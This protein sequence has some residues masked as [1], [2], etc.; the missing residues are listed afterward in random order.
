MPFPFAFAWLN[1][2]QAVRHS[3]NQ[4]YPKPHDPCFYTGFI[5]DSRDPLALASLIPLSPGLYVDDFVYFSEDPAVES[6]FE[7]L[8]KEQV[9]VDFRGLTEWFLGI[10]FHGVSQNWWWL[11]IR[12]NRGMQQI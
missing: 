6:L 7:L 8:L 11:F 3:H 5:L 4:P 9:N 2:I 1:A 10:H 12:T